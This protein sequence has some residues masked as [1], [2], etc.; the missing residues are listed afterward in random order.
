EPRPALAE[1]AFARGEKAGGRRRARE[2]LELLPPGGDA[3][4]QRRR[5]RLR[6]RL[7][8]DEGLDRDFQALA[9]SAP[10]RAEVLVDWVEAL[11][12]H[13]WLEEAAEPLALLKERFP[14][15]RADSRPL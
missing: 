13:G 8:W 3:D 7:S 11:L 14:A 4:A 6:A 5:L 10:G 15:R 2:A 1:L 9:D 12:E